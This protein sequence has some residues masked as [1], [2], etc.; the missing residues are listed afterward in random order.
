MQT[1]VL[2]HGGWRDGTAWDPVIEHLGNLG[3]LA[4]GPT[5]AGHGN[6]VNKVVSHNDCVSSIV[7][8]IVEHDLTHVA[9]LGHSF[10]GSVIARVAEEIPERLRRLIFWN[11]FVPQ[12]G[13]CVLDEM[14]PSY[15]D[16]FSTLAAQSDDNTVALPFE[17]WRETFMQDAD[18]ETAH[19]I[20]ST[21]SP[22]PLQPFV[23]KLDLTRFFELE[24][25]KSF[26]NCMEDTALPPGEWGWHP[27][28]SQRLGMY[29]L[30]QMHGS[31]EA[32]FMRAEELAR[33]IVEAGR[34]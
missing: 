26:I 31:H 19:S 8:F 34:D 11:A 24:I 13:N 32:A 27:R 18:L 5:M 25:P 21:L 16:L 28:M 10:G 3:H 12:N 33:K 15:R 17:V 30:V 7:Q 6:D 2:V 1:F 9:L 22:E 4:Y 14:P 23:D 29:R 20:Y